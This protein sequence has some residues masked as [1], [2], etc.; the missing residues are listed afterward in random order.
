MHDAKIECLT[1]IIKTYKSA[2]VAYSGGVD[3]VFLARVAGEALKGNILLVTA[4]SST[5]PAAELDDSKRIAAMLELPQRIIESEELDIPGFSENSPLRCY[6]CKK[7]LFSH[8]RGIAEREGFSVVFDGANADDR[9]DYRPGARAAKELGIRSPLA[10]A[11]LTKNEIRECSR[12]LGLPTAEKPSLACLASRFPYG[13]PITKKKLNRVDEAEK[14]LRDL[15]FTQLRV[16]SHGD[17]AR[18]E[19]VESEIES[20]WKRRAALQSACINAGFIHV[21]IDTR[22]YRTGAMNEGLRK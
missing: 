19:L 15:G 13:E 10:E 17:L 2:L 8:I 11:G 4:T 18:I 21:A 16:R 20:G 6:F 9:N 1:G 12:E 14:A 3:S 7:T 22:G 5:Y